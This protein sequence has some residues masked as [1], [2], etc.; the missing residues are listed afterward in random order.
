MQLVLAAKARNNGLQLV[1]DIQNWIVKPCMIE[2]RHSNSYEQMGLPTSLH[3]NG[4]WGKTIRIH[5]YEEGT[6]KPELNLKS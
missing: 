6:L 2:V 1:G 5:I 3:L 4:R